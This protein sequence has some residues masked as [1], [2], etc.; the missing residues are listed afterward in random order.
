M[1]V[2]ALVLVAM[3]SIALSAVAGDGYTFHIWSTDG[4]TGLKANPRFA[5]L[6]MSEDQLERASHDR[7]VVL[8][9]TSGANW[10]W[11]MLNWPEGKAG[12]EQGINVRGAGN[13]EKDADLGLIP[14]GNTSMTTRCL[15][16]RCRLHITTADKK[17][18]SVLLTRNESLPIAFDSTVA[19]SF[20][21]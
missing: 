21:R 14:N 15:Q 19:V 3:M 17:E 13:V 11:L 8:D 5:E 4:R 16:E 9:Q 2:K 7:V 10:V 12:A 1:R 6:K 18:T 20:E